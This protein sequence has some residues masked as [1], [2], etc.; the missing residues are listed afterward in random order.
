MNAP[1]TTDP[2]AAVLPIEAR[3]ALLEAEIAFQ[4]ARAELAAAEQH[5]YAQV[6]A[7]YLAVGRDRLALLA[8][9]PSTITRA[10]L[11]GA[12]RRHAEPSEW[13][14]LDLFELENN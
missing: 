1:A 7:G 8:E 3:T 4:A 6:W 14:Q 12:I 2:A 5:R 10:T 13:T 9:T 11:A